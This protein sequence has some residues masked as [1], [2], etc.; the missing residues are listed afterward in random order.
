MAPQQTADVPA[1]GDLVIIAAHRVGEREQLGE[2]LEVFAGQRPHYR[3]RWEDG[4][5]SLFFPSSDATVRRS[6]HRRGP[7]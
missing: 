3:V 6:S 1:A 2:I 4:H 7:S 5:E